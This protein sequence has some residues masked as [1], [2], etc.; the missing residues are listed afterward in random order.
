MS[1]TEKWSS[2]RARSP[3]VSRPVNIQEIGNPGQPTELVIHN[4][5]IYCYDSEGQ[6]LIAGGII[7]TAAIAA[8]SIVAT[9]IAIGQS[10]FTHNITHYALNYFQIYF[11]AGTIYFANGQ[12]ITTSE[13]WLNVFAT[14][15]VYYDGESALYATTDPSIVVGDDKVLLAICR[16]GS[17]WGQLVA[18]EYQ[19]AAGTTIEGGQITTDSIIANKLDVISIDASGYISASYIMTGTMSV[20]GSGA[21]SPGKLSFL[22]TNDIEFG[23]VNYLG[24]IFDNARG[25]FLHNVGQAGNPGLFYMDT[26]NDLWIG[27]GANEKV[28][29]ARNSDSA[30]CFIFDT[31]TGVIKYDL[32]GNYYPIGSNYSD[33]SIILK[34]AAAFWGDGYPSIQTTYNFGVTLIGEPLCFGMGLGLINPINSFGTGLDTGYTFSTTDGGAANEQYSQQ[35]SMGGTGR[36]IDAISVVMAKTGTPAGT[37]VAEI[38]ADSGGLPTGAALGT[39]NALTINT[40]VLGTHPGGY[41][42]IGFTFGTPISLSASTVYHLVIRTIGFT[43]DAGVTDLYWGGDAGGIHTG[44]GETYDDGGSTWSAIAPA[45]VLYFQIFPYNYFGATTISAVTDFFTVMGEDP[46]TTSIKLRFIQQDLGNAFQL[47]YRYGVLLGVFGAL[48]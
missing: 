6:T 39:S 8:R 10:A 21:V 13:G 12:S 31:S 18:I 2:S 27:S 16:P 14:T 32:L 44:D 36:D 1:N 41:G 15:Y 19:Q 4:G 43:Q 29:I 23:K 30:S 9:K 7:Q 45:T 26:N 3:G 38:F 28:R 33:G 24:L 5:K 25:V 48:S 20:G 37:M 35:F 22:D 40:V 46:T 42:F 11:Y 47:G 34:G 17:Q